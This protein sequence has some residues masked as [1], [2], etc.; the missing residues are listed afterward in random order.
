MTTSK[1]SAAYILGIIALFSVL[2]GCGEPREAV[3]SGGVAS[4]QAALE[5]NGDADGDGVPD[6]SDNCPGI[7]NPDQL[8][9]SGDGPGDA[10]ELQLVFQLGANNRYVK[11]RS[12]K[13]LVVSTTPLVLSGAPDLIGI[14]ASGP[15]GAAPYYYADSKRIGVQSPGEASSEAVNPGETLVLRLGTASA[16]GGARADRAFLH[17]DGEASVIVRLFDGSVLVGTSSFAHTK[18]KLVEV[19]AAGSF[20]R[21]ELSVAS[22]AVGVRGVGGAVMFGLTDQLH[23][24]RGQLSV[25]RLPGRLQWHGPWGLCRHRRVRERR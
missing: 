11:F 10:C 3:E 24:H 20:D 23:E 12:A 13:E 2:A 18:K 1:T 7:A 22:G 5:A 19:A 4:L 25:R 15:S 14:T 9:T 17:L 21:L 6:A 16:L 8:N